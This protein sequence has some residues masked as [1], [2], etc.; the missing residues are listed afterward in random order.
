MILFYAV[1]HIFLKCC[2]VV[3]V[4]WFVSHSVRQIKSISIVQSMD[5]NEMMNMIIVNISSDKTIINSDLVEGDVINAICS[6][7]MTRSIP[8]RTPGYVI[9]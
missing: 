2:H 4:L 6:Q 7:I 5:D 8:A 9:F 1:E 3:L